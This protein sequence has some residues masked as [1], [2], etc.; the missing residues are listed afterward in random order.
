MES[1]LRKLLS[2]RRHKARRNDAT[3]ELDLQSIPYGRAP[4]QGRLPVL[5]NQALRKSGA[6]KQRESRLPTDPLRSFSYQEAAAGKPPQLGDR[7]QRGNG[8]VKLQTS[9]RLSSGELLVTEQ[10]YDRT[11]EEIREGEYIVG[12]K[13]RRASK[14]S[15]QPKSPTEPTSL[16]F[17][18]TAPSSPREQVTFSAPIWQP[19]SGL[20][21]FAP[22][23]SPA[24]AS[25]IFRPPQR[26][27]SAQAYYPDYRRDGL[28]ISSPTQQ[29]YARPMTSTTSLL[30]PHE[31]RNP[32]IEALWK[33]ESSRLMSMSGQTG[34]DNSTL[35]LDKHHG[36]APLPRVPFPMEHR[37]SNSYSYSSRSVSQPT[38]LP[39][40]PAR[41]GASLRM[42]ASTSVL[43]L[44]YRDDHSEG[45]SQPRYSHLSSSGASSSLTTR[46]S[47]AEEP[48]TTRD[49]IRK[50][51]DDMR[52]TYLQAIEAQT[53]PLQ[54]VSSSPVDKA[55]AKARTPSLMSYASVDSSLRS[56]SRHSTTRTKSW[57]SSTSQFA[58]AR[59]SATSPMMKPKRPGSATSRRTSGQTAAGIATL[60]PI[61]ASPAKSAKSS[62]TKKVHDGGLKRADSTTLGVMA[63]KLT[64][65]DDRHS[66]G[67]S[68]HGSSSK[69]AP[70]FY[71]SSETDSDSSSSSSASAASSPMRVSSVQH[72]PEKHKAAGR[73]QSPLAKQPWQIDVDQ[74]LPDEDLELA[75]DIDE[76]E[77]LCDGLFNSPSASA[78]TG[79][80]SGGGA[81]GGLGMFQP[82]DGPGT[83]PPLH[84]RANTFDH[85]AFASTTPAELRTSKFAKDKLQLGLGLT[86]L[87]A[88]I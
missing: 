51:V 28:G 33:A 48:G 71:N 55:R 83:T 31:E 67:S 56:A 50:I 45:S 64:V 26:S 87:P 9:R 59:A 17:I 34:V 12:G 44:A 77:T 36:D 11:L 35:E 32:T 68:R 19:A 30:E 58:T 70:T 78:S 38:Y 4:S 54:P 41:A 80:G 46:T 21:E 52:T 57:Q 60:T 86:G 62:Q 63:R 81:G 53:P 43:D 20:G 6:V 40:S 29:L 25:S 66:T 49:D 15:S 69:P 5:I 2:P 74:I 75:L 88:M 84:A 10:D 79:V 37:R 73:Q 16:K 22:V 76:F 27:Y 7:P 65:V 82:W 8:P 72:T 42:N 14:S 3:A 39:T 61:E 1:R 18:S 47:I 24:S 85:D 13:E 23:A